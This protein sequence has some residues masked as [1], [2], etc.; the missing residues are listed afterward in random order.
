[1]QVLD[2][3]VWLWESKTQCVLLQYEYH[4][5]ALY[6]C[7]SQRWKRTSNNHQNNQSLNL[8]N[9]QTYYQLPQHAAWWGKYIDGKG[10]QRFVG[11]PALRSTQNLG[12]H[13]LFDW[14]Q[15]CLSNCQWGLI[16]L[17]LQ[18]PCWRSTKRTMLRTRISGTWGLRFNLMDLWIL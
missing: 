4:S 17:A 18:K 1:M 11:T 16:Q 9:L 8:Y 15:S 6:G 10:R 7:S 2:D 14:L 3:V 5:E 12:S 13:S